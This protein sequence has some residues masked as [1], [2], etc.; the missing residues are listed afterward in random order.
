MTTNTIGLLKVIEEAGT[1][2]W[3]DVRLTFPP[4]AFADDQ[5]PDDQDPDD[6]DS[7]EIR[8]GDLV[9]SL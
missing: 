4:I 1:S 6:D 2:G 8:S 3:T 7:D 5:D 9:T